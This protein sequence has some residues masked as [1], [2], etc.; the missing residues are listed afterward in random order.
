MLGKIHW[1]TVLAALG[2]AG[3][4]PYTGLITHDQTQFGVCALGFSSTRH[5]FPIPDRSSDTVLKGAL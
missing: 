4:M 5:P 3:D 1:T 2:L